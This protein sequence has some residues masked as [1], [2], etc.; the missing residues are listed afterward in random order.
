MY[1]WH[2]DVAK[3]VKHKIILLTL[4]PIK[5]KKELKSSILGFEVVKWKSLLPP[6]LVLILY[7]YNSLLVHVEMFL[8]M[9]QCVFRDRVTRVP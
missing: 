3:N 9:C 5:S 1:Y 6:M 7:A 8:S 2:N 4:R